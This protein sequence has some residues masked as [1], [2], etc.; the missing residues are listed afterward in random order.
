MTT[1]VTPDGT[2][3]TPQ[4]NTMSAE[5]A[6][7]MQLTESDA[8]PLASV[9]TQHNDNMRTG[10][11][12]HEVILKPSN[13]GPDKFGML[14]KREVRGQIYAQ[15]LYLPNVPIP[16]K[17]VHN[18]VYVATMHNIVYAFDADHAHHSEPLW[19]R[20][21]GT[22]V[23]LPDHNIGPLV[24]RDAV[25]EIGILSTPVIDPV[26]KRLYVVAM[27]R[28]GNRP[29]TDGSY[30][31]FLYALD[32]RTGDIIHAVK[33]EASVPGQASKNE[34]GNVIFE[35]VRQ[36]QRPGL[37]LVHGNI[38][39]AFAAFGD[40]KPYHGWVLAYS[41][42]TLAQ[43]SVYN[44]TPH[45]KSDNEAGI[46]QAGQGLAVDPEGFLYFM[47]GNGTFRPD[48]S[49]LGDSIIKLNKDLKLVDWF[50]PYNTEILNAI[51]MDLGSAGMLVIPHTRYA[52]GGG[53]EG[54]FYLLDR[55]RLG[56]FNRNND[57]QI[58]QNFYASFP[59]DPS[60]PYTNDSKKSMHIHGGPPYWVGPD[61]KGYIYV[62]P[63]NDYLKSFR[64]DGN[65]FHTEPASQYKLDV[66]EVRGVRGMPGGIL[67]LSAHGNRDGILWASHPLYEDA[68]QKTVEGIFYAFDATNL[69]EPLWSSEMRPE[70]DYP[71]NFAKFS[72]PTIANG[73]VY[74][75][76]F[77]N[78]LAVYG[79]LTPHNPSR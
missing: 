6:F 40:R 70:R 62:W 65:R 38:Y 51:D 77:S 59:I 12:L 24:Y 2:F 71:G 11:S 28:R 33:I 78:Y 75:A 22:P 43:V 26:R 27:H 17:G 4:D 23:S 79:L 52:L 9:L 57:N 8:D 34:S 74:L 64:F 66:P 7:L 31:H 30:S 1:E 45:H 10:A 61:G 76:T 25:E 13:V 37:T 5:S 39:I 55:S 41:A 56:H 50:T 68:N 60:V 47:T 48:G 42:E 18:V 53:K 58:P 20:D 46:W 29:Y 19:R 49:A 69:S 54:K 73:K 16:D 32:V 3:F 67:S 15:P 36:D 14:F 44:T 72:P 35:S 21:L 63:E